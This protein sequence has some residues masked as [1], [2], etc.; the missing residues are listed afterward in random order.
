[1]KM[2]KMNFDLLFWKLCHIMITSFQRTLTL[3]FQLRTGERNGQL[4][5]LWNIQ[6][7]FFHSQKIVIIT[8][9]LKHNDL[10]T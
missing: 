3:R 6:K 2:L 7:S 9:S 10:I 1:M 8:A 5:L 4:S